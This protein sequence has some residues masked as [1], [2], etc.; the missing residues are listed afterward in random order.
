MVDDQKQALQVGAFNIGQEDYSM[1][2]AFAL[3]VGETSLDVLKTEME[4]EF[5]K[6]RSELISE[7]DYQKLLNKFENQFVNSNSSVE[8]IAN[9]LARNYMLYGDTELINKEI[10]IYRS[11]SREE[12]KEVANRF[13]NPNQRLVLDYLPKEKTEN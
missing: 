10:E 1:Y 2:V 11:I 8:G 4:E 6:V 7:K 12:I 13:L 3:P 9:S 5:A